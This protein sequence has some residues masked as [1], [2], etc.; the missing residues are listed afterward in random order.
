M[1]PSAPQR[2]GSGGE[3]WRRSRPIP[4]AADQK[5]PLKFDNVVPG[6]TTHRSSVTPP[7]T[8]T[9]APTTLCR[10]FAEGSTEAGKMHP[11][12]GSTPGQANKPEASS[13]FRRWYSETVPRSA[14]GD[15]SMIPRTGA[16]ESTQL[17][18]ALRM[19]QPDSG[20]AE[21][22]SGAKMWTPV[23]I[24]TSRTRPSFGVPR[25]L[26]TQPCSSTPIEP[27]RSGFGVRRSIIV[28]TAPRARCS[29]EA[30]RRSGANSVSPFM[31][32]TGACES[33]NKA[34]AARS[35]PPVPSRVSSRE[36]QSFTPCGRAAS[37]T[38][39]TRSA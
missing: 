1:V 8:S 25:R 22:A 2:Q 7:R 33:S 16:P 34:Y 23:N 10:M 27:K 19:T 37:S 35:P 31:T 26:L 39:S 36:K 5:P 17:R 24:S 6:Q 13:R 21:K 14:Q 11:S 28:A 32:V 18:Y 29:A 30:C 4:S 15:S 38:D 20:I 9:S 12:R 3:L